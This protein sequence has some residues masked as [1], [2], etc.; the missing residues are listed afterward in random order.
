[1]GTDS[2]QS[3]IMLFCMIIWPLKIYHD[4]GGFAGIYGPNCQNAVC[5]G[6]KCPDCAGWTCAL[7][8]G[9]ATGCLWYTA[10]QFTIYPSHEK[11]DM[12]NSPTSPWRK[13]LPA[14]PLPPATPAPTPNITMDFGSNDT[15]APTPAPTAAPT[16]T[17]TGNITTTSAPTPAPLIPCTDFRLPPPCPVAAYDKSIYFNFAA[18]DMLS[19]TILWPGVQ[20]S[21]QFIQ[22]ILSAKSDG[23]IRTSQMLLIPMAV[24][25]F[26]PA[27][28]IGLTAKALYP[29]EITPSQTAFAVMVNQL[30]MESGFPSF[31][32]ILLCCSAVAAIMSTADSVCIAA[33]NIIT[34]ELKS[35]VQAWREKNNLPPMKDQ[36]WVMASK[37]IS[38]FILFCACGIGNDESLKNDPNA[39]GTLVSWQGALGAPTVA[40]ALAVLYCE[41]RWIS[42]WAALWSGILGVVVVA[43]WEAGPAVDDIQSEDYTG[44]KTGF[45]NRPPMFQQ[46]SST[47]AIIVS[48]ISYPILCYVFNNYLPSFAEDNDESKM[49]WIRKW[50]C[51]HKCQRTW[52]GPNNERIDDAYIKKVMS[53]TREPMT[54]PR[55]KMLIAY[56]IVVLLLVMPWYE[57]SHALAKIDTT[58]KI[59]QWASIFMVMI[60]LNFV[61]STYLIASWEVSSSNRVEVISKNKV[62]TFDDKPQ[63]PAIIKDVE[64]EVLQ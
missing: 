23:A 37:L 36:T 25:A 21:P 40:A 42:G 11:S 61:V 31:L 24:V 19:F 15:F 44:G 2:L 60:C 6:G 41:D 12:C 35:D 59:P 29:S 58:A 28:M 18:V 54:N 57:K 52:D 33:S 39:Y 56:Q 49:H 55:T 34:V 26:L 51:I 5:V 38:L 16:P 48:F 17:P 7:F 22:R 30:R 64:E 20:L 8:P 53:G 46:F 27:I 43:A 3:A 63:P 13:D 45:G 14:A 32:G 1:M 62:G 4:H 47:W 10:P 9:K 50:D